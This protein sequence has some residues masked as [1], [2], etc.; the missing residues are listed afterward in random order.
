[1]SNISYELESLLIDDEKEIIFEE[2]K[3]S[4]AVFISFKINIYKL[5]E[6]SSS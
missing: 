6:Q 2:T 3:F 4:S 5:Q 1:M